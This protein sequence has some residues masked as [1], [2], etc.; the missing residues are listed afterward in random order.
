[1]NLSRAIG[2]V[3]LLIAFS[4]TP[5]LSDPVDGG[6]SR[7]ILAAVKMLGETRAS[8][9]YGQAAFTQDLTF[10]DRGVLKA[11]KPPITMC[12][13]AQLEVLVEALN[14]YANDTGSKPKDY[15]PFHFLPKVTWERLRPLDLRGQIWIVKNSN[16]TGAAQAFENFGMG[17]R[18]SF[19]HLFPGAFLNFNRTNKTGH[20]VMFLGYIDKA[21][22]DLAG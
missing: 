11:S 4:T 6:F 14:L 15:S 10:G 3:A 18:I 13:A 22:V 1:M 2:S 16:S 12:V 7:Y 9:G 17:Q 5:A 21:G 20:G 19:D 8:L